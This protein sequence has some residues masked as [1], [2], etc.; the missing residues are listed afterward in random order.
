VRPV[1]DTICWL[2]SEMMPCGSVI[3]SASMFDSISERV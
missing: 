2:T 3:M 1:S